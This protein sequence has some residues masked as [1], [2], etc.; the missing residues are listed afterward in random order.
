MVLD[1]PACQNAVVFM[2]FCRWL[3]AQHFCE[4]FGGN[5]A[6]SVDQ[7]ALV[8]YANNGR[9]QTFPT[10]AAIENIRNATGELFIDVRCSCGAQLAIQISARCSKW[11]AECQKE[12]LQCRMLRE[13][14]GNGVLPACNE[15]AD[16]TAFGVLQ[17]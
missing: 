13:A 10:C 8:F 15:W 12:F 9:F 14:N 5:A 17:T 1:H 16:Q 7:H 11:P 6:V 3:V 2:D 4:C